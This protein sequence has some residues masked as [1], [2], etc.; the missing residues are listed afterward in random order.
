MARL[1]L[2]DLDNTL[3]DRTTAFR[4]W[5]QKF[6]AAND[7]PPG[8]WSVIES[9]D[10]DGMAPRAD[11]FVEICRQLRITREIEDL[12][13]SYYQEYPRCFTVDH[14]TVAA[15]RKLRARGW[16]VGVV[17]NGPPSQGAK[18]EATNLVGEVDA[19]CI[20]AVVGAWKPDTAIFEEAARICGVPLDGWMVGDSANAD[21]EGGRRAGLHTIWMARGREWDAS[22]VAPD[23][24]VKT[25]PEAVEIILESVAS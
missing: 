2:F 7:L 24:V 16:K 19:H 21:I 14:E 15:V 8:A 6:I 5:A 11:F 22:L 17:T 13:T 23:A 4:I 18:L 10:G 3:L 12:L 1:A 20:S 9:A 25:I